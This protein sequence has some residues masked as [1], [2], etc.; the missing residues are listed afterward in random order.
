MLL[1]IVN[2]VMAEKVLYT[3]W[4]QDFAKNAGMY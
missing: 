2:I 3:T 4:K 1:N